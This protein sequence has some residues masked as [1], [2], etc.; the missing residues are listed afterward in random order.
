MKNIALFSAL[1]AL[2]SFS[3]CEEDTV[4]TIKGCTDVTANNYFADA[5]ED[6][7]SCT[8]DVE[9]C[10]DATAANYD[11]TANVD[12][13]SCT[14]FGDNFAGTYAVEEACT[15]GE[16]TYD[17]VITANGNEIT[18]VNAFGWSAGTQNDLTITI[19]GNTFSVTGLETIIE[20]NGNEFPGAFDLD[21]DLD[22]NVLTISYTLYLDTDGSGLAVYDECV[23][24]CTLGGGKATFTSSKKY[25]NL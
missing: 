20:G 24:T 17:Q 4:E 19:T 8:Y 11:A 6:D 3:S 5:T 10:T 14:Y 7:G 23:A 15:G 2:L 25:L 13:G 1:A 12:N 9:G 22:G 16:Y 21:A 18:L